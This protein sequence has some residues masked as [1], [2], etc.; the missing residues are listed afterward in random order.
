MIT[1]LNT[2]TPEVDIAGCRR[3]PL[4]A[5]LSMEALLKAMLFPTRTVLL[6]FA[7][8][9]TYISRPTS[10]NSDILRRATEPW[11]RRRMGMHSID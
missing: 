11:D 10:I 5:P 7:R 6:T 1:P 9:A 4:M 3:K 2:E 8:S